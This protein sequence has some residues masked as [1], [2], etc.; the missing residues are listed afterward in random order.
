MSKIEQKEKRSFWRN[1]KWVLL[2]VVPILLSGLIFLQRVVKERLIAELNQ[3]LDVKVVLH[4]IE[5]SGL[6]NFPNVGVRFNNLRVDQSFPAFQGHL[7]EARY[8][9]VVVNAMD[10]IKGKNTVQKVEIYDGELK[11]FEDATQNNYSIFKKNPDSTNNPS[12]KA[13]QIDLKKVILNNVRLVYENKVDQQSLNC[14][15]QNVKAKAKYGDD[16][17]FLSLEG[18]SIFD[19]FEIEGTEYLLGKKIQMDLDI[20]V[21]QKTKSYYVNKGKIVIDGLPLNLKGSAIMQDGHP[22]L[23]VNFESTNADI[24]GL[25]ALLPKDMAYPIRDWNSDGNLNIKG[26]AKGIISPSVFPIIDV[27]FDIL[28]GQLRNEGRQVD[29]G[30]LKLN[31]SLSNHGKANIDDLELQ[32]IIEEFKTKKSSLQGSL[33]VPKLGNPNTSFTL[34]GHLYLDDLNA[35]FPG[36]DI[37]HGKLQMNTEGMLKWDEEI[38]NFNYHRSG[39]YGDIELSSFDLLRNGMII[40]DVTASGRLKARDWNNAA[41]KGSIQ[42]SQFEFSGNITDWTSGIFAGGN[43]RANIKGELSVGDFNLNDFL[44]KPESTIPTEGKVKNMEPYKGQKMLD[45]GWDA[46]I[47]LDAG[48]FA[49]NEMSFKKIKAK[50]Q[51]REKI[52][53][54][55]SLKLD[56]MEGE[57]SV[58]TSFTQEDDRII[59][60]GNF[61]LKNF[62][63]SEFFRQ[64]NNFEQDELTDK[65]LSGY[66]TTESDLYMQFDHHWN[67]ITK[68]M[69]LLAKINV[70]D[71]VLKDYKTLE[72]LSKFVEVEDLMDVRFSELKNVIRIE[73]ETIHIPTMSIKNSALNLE[74]SGTHTFANYVDYKLKLSL[75]ELL[76]KKSGW[77]HKRKQKQLESESGGGMNAYVLMKGTV[78]DLEI[79][80]DKKA[81]TTKIKHEAKAERKRFFEDIKKEIRGERVESTKEEPTLWDE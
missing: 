18:G 61:Y 80:F 64:F 22:N 30:H 47:K 5:I 4:S 36:S 68:D 48:T 16:K 81:V 49:Y 72:S 37:Q 50:V 70:K 62:L 76:A 17:F 55:P 40:Q 42:G 41:V 15:A 74:I 31:G 33:H 2:F 7:L 24:K 14:L 29:L 53:H 28:N 1:L 66:L 27:E 56:G 54:V 73:D 20:E 60:S 43:K 51:L 71:G 12:E 32:V 38:E 10:L 67:A 23:D 63:I 77:I 11:I 34:K 3:Q 19:H 69:I 78:P 79:K 58:K 8:I 21:N 25:I 9:N 46:D 6:S 75:T 39:F 44:A 35:V 13:F 65:N 59:W 52:I 57:A 45:I 26:S